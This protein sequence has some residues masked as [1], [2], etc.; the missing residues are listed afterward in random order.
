MFYFMYNIVLDIDKKFCIIYVTYINIYIYKLC[1]L[2][3]AIL[4]YSMIYD[5]N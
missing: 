4:R 2:L 5:D 3:L 1:I